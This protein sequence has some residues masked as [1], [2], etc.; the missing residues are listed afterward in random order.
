MTEAPKQRINC[1]CGVE[2]SV[3]GSADS[4]EHIHCPVCGSYYDTELRFQISKAQVATLKA[5]RSEWDKNVVRADRLPDGVVWQPIETAPRDG[6]DVLLWWP[7][8]RKKPIIGRYENHPTGG[9]WN[10]EAKLIEYGQGVPDN[11][12]DPTHWKPLD[13]PPKVATATE[14]REGGE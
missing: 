6:T 4:D 3:Q 5:H 2:F 9:Y 11:N 13:A 10:T 1:V 7:Y 14:T 12:E 8:W